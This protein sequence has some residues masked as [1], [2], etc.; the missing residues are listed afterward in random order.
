MNS[1][2]IAEMSGLT[3]TRQWFVYGAM[4]IIVAY[5]VLR[6]AVNFRELLRLHRFGQRRARYYYAVRVWRASPGQ[7]RIFLVWECLVVDTLCVLLL[8]L[9]VPGDFTLW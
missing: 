9:L 8:I 1:A 7:L 3:L 4:L 6:T 2:F 5:A